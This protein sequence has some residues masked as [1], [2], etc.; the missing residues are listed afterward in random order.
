MKVIKEEYSKIGEL[1][2]LY[3]VP[4]SYAADYNKADRSQY[5]GIINH[6]FNAA[7]LNAIKCI[8]TF[9]NVTI[10]TVLDNISKYDAGMVYIKNKKMLIKFDEYIYF[11]T[12]QMIVD[13]F[14]SNGSEVTHN[15]DFKIVDKKR[16]NNEGMKY[17][18]D[19]ASTLRLQNPTLLR[20]RNK[21]NYT[22]YFGTFYNITKKYLLHFMT[23]E[24]IYK[25]AKNSFFRNLIDGLKEKK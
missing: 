13:T 22:P 7:D 3:N 24:D 20:I 9:Y 8:G 2:F 11:R 14:A 10:D 12:T 21:R 1:A 16:L 15:F 25:R 19:L 4:I 17:L 18:L 6:K 23:E 5:R